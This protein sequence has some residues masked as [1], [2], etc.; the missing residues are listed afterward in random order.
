[1]RKSIRLLLQCKKCQ[2]PGHL[3]RNC[4]ATTPTCGKCSGNHETQGCK[5]YYRS[6]ANCKTKGH[7]ASDRVCPAAIRRQEDYNANILENTMPFF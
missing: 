6:C 4:P 7:G 5:S 2:G 1:V 3:A